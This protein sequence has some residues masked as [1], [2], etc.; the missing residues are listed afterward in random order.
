MP[1]HFSL[2]AMAILANS[3]AHATTISA[4]SQ[5]EAQGSFADSIDY[6]QY[7]TENDF[8]F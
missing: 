4:L 2:I 3:P 1:K 5:V 6:I 8:T 7:K